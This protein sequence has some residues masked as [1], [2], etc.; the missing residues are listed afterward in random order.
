MATPSA[1]N[2]ANSFGLIGS[3]IGVSPY[4]QSYFSS[5]DFFNRARQAA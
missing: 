1:A 5:I 3:G 4:L 2:F